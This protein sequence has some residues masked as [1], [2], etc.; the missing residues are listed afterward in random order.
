MNIYFLAG[1]GNGN[2][3]GDESVVIGADQD[4]V[5]V[6]CSFDEA[7]RL[8]GEWGLHQPLLAQDGIHYSESG[9]AVYI[10]N[11]EQVNSAEAVAAVF[12]WTDEHYLDAEDFLQQEKRVF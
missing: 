2:F 12:G 7:G 5:L 9:D 4:G 10:A 6:K 3:D 8:A 1:E 11:G